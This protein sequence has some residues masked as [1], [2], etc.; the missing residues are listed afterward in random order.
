[1]L[2][3]GDK[4]TYDQELWDNADERIYLG[5]SLFKGIEYVP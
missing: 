4:N 1:V 2:A 5:V 3:H